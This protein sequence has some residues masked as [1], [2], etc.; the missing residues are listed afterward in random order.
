MTDRVLYCRIS[1]LI[2]MYI[3]DRFIVFWAHA[4]VHDSLP[5][6]TLGNLS[7][8]ELM[9]SNLHFL[10][11]TKLTLSVPTR[12]QENRAFATIMAAISHKTVYDDSLHF[13]IFVLYTSQQISNEVV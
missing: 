13:S 9:T 2:R 10:V 6:V 4:E 5:A 1:I 3:D 11:V 7:Q 12:I 8:N